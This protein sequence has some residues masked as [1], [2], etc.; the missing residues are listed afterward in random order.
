MAAFLP[1]QKFEIK[2]RLS[3]AAT[4][5][6]LGEIVEPLAVIFFGGPTIVF[7]WEL[8]KAKKLLNAQLETDKFSLP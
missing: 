5:Q 2:T 6:K 3:A 8:N 7:H 4:R 1:Y